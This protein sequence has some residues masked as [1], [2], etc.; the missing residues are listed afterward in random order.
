MSRQLRAIAFSDAHIHKFKN[1][2]VNNSRL[3]WCIKSIFHI[4][5]VAV[6][7][8]VPVLFCGDLIHSPKDIETETNEVVQGLFNWWKN[9]EIPFIAIDGNHDQSQRNSKDKRSPSHINALHCK[10]VVNVSWSS[11]LSDNLEVWGI[12]YVHNDLEIF[13][14]VRSIK[15]EVKE[16]HARLKILLLHTDMPG[17]KTPTGFI[18]DDTKHIPKDLDKFFKDFDLVLCGHI[19]KPQWL[20]KKC[21]MLGCPIQQDESNANDKLGYWEIYSDGSAKLIELKEYPKFIR[22]K[23]GEVAPADTIDYYIP[24]DEVLEEEDVEIGEF[25]LNNSKKELAKSYCRQTKVKSKAKRNA[26]IQILNEAQ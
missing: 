11:T 16:S 3:D 22:L 13:N 1:F 7:K 14:H 17:C 15:K 6:E 26:L 23:K 5:E 19:H 18:L 4:L 12:P 2:N 21:I 20:S 24:F 10:G 9:K 8:N 25:N